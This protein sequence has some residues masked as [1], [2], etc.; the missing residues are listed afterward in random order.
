MGAMS[1]WMI[2][3]FA[4]GAVV[5]WLGEV[6]AGLAPFIGVTIGI[7]SAAAALLSVVVLV[8]AARKLR[9]NSRRWVRVLAVV[10][11]VAEVLAIT[12]FTLVSVIAFVAVAM[13]A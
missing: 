8:V 11:I 10:L 7:V 1:L 13:L 12:A 5:M 6:I 2:P 9:H 4:I 3:F